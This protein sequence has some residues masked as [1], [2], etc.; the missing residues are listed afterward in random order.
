MEPLVHVTEVPG[1]W[2]VSLVA[3]PWQIVLSIGVVLVMTLI[4]FTGLLYVMNRFRI[5]PKEIGPIKF[6][7]E[8]SAKKFTDS[9]LLMDELKSE[10]QR[11]VYF[12][13]YVEILRRQMRVIELKTAEM[14][15]MMRGTFVD[16]VSAHIGK[17][18]AYESDTVQRY[19]I[20]TD[21]IEIV[22]NKTMRTAMRENHLTE[23]TD[24]DWR[25]YLQSKVKDM[26]RVIDDTIT[27]IYMTDVVSLHELKEMNKAKSYEFSKIIQDMLEQAREISRSGK[28]RIDNLKKDY[29][30]LTTRFL[31]HGEIKDDSMHALDEIE[32]ADGTCTDED[33]T[34]CW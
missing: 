6:L 19:K 9:L 30:E 28:K 10:I 11:Q 34:F 15:D 13:E 33:K 22:I 32:A 1:D 26:M 14:I 18:K 31:V 3:N 17:E 25:D 4:A 5:K 12:I 16:L 20:M 8:E 29:K 2:L 27:S 21:F 24:I 7:N 23:R